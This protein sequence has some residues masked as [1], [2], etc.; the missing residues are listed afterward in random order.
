MRIVCPSCQAAYEVP[1]KVLT[2]G[3][4]A[5]RCARCGTEWAPAAVATPPADAP[6]DAS[7]QLPAAVP[8]LPPP[9][10]RAARGESRLSSYRPRTEER[11]ADVWPPTPD[12][13]RPRGGRSVIIGWLLSIIVLVGLAGA[14]VSWRNQVMSAWPASER[15]FMALGLD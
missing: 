7:P 10:E 2:A 13:A 15:L 9:G 14:A 1:E 4:K 5:V 8:S 12:D 11:D 3:T 6:A